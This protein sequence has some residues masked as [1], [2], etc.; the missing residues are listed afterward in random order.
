MEALVDLGSRAVRAL[1]ETEGSYLPESLCVEA[2][3][4]SG[5]DIGQKI[6]VPRRLRNAMRSN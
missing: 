6:Q 4:P 2:G 5:V 1:Q 3:R